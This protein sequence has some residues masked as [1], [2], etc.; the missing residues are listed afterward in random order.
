MKTKAAI[1]QI[2]VFLLLTN[3]S[4][5]KQITIPDVSE[6]KLIIVGLIEYN[7]TQLKNKRIKG[8][9]IY[10]DSKNEAK[11]FSLSSKFLPTD[12]NKY[13]K[14]I[15]KIGTKGIYELVYQHSNFSGELDYLV[16]LME[17]DKNSNSQSKIPIQEY[18]FNDC[19][20]INIGKII[21]NYKGGEI[22]DGIINYSYT[23]SY[24]SNDTTSL[25]A[26]KQT[27][28]ALFD[29]FKNDICC[30][31]GDFEQ[32]IDYLLAHI[33]EGKKIV[34]KQFIEDHPD[35]TK[36]VFKDISL[37]NIQKYIEM[38]EKFSFDELNEFL[39]SK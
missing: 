16:S 37:D 20:I 31:K 15:S 28:P 6:G 39:N 3:C 26:L 9:D 19:K 8:I 17:L 2:I 32:S 13:Y 21:V 4:T 7:Y 22:V 25:F 24:R 38:I 5:K 23:F 14:Y 35:K 36:I 33:S 27:Y 29:A 18:T 12:E 1:L 34:V 30:F 10:L 11:N